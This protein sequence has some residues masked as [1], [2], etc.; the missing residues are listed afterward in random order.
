M[1]DW[2]DNVVR[3]TY[4]EFSVIDGKWKWTRIHRTRGSDA[5]R[6]LAALRSRTSTVRSVH[7]QPDSRE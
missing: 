7:A 2:R 3:I 5:D 4:E 1:E 6:T